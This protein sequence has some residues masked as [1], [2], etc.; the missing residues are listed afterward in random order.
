MNFGF[1]VELA[2]GGGATT[3]NGTVFTVFIYLSI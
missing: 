2:G 3:A 1:E